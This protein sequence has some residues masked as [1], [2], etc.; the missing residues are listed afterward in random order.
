MN[1]KCSRHHFVIL[2]CTALAFA[3]SGCDENP[4][5]RPK[6]NQPPE[7]H[8]FL[9]PDRQLATTQS[10]QTLHWWGD[11]PDGRVI[12]YLYTFA[13]DPQDITEFDSTQ[14]T[15]WTFTQAMQ[16]TFSL[17]FTGTDSVFRFQ[18][19]AVDDQNAVDPTPATLDIPVKNSAPEVVFVPSATVPDTTFTAVVFSWTGTDLDGDETIQAYEYVLDDTTAAWVEIPGKTTFVLLKEQDGITEGE[20]AFYLRAV[21]IAGARSETIRMPE[22][23]DRT[24]YVKR[25]RGR[26]LVLDDYGILDDAPAFYGGTLDTLAGE[27]STLDIKHDGNRDGQPDLLPGSN[28]ALVETMKL[29]EAVIWYGDFATNFDVARVVVPQYLESGGKIL[30]SMQFTAAF[31]NDNDELE[32]TPAAGLDQNIGRLFNGASLLPDPSRPDLPELQVKS[33]TNVILNVK[34]IVGKPTAQPLY[35][36]P[37]GGTYT[38]TPILALENAQKTFVLFVVPFHQLNNLGTASEVLSI[39]FRSEFGVY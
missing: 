6:T 8:L 11:D 3:L 34:S 24:W 7:T 16:K 35:R 19:S 32:F 1:K 20:H 15:D 27:Y 17:R 37:E 33:T 29:F 4:P 36:L 5:A 39:V 25:P 38:G 9:Q 2:L 13:P 21:D 26:V 28:L 14:A 30:F 18:I 10:L 12:G 23:P 31:A 22:N